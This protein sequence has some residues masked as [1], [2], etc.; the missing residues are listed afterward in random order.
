LPALPRRPVHRL[1]QTEVLM[2]QPLTLRKGK[3]SASILSSGIHI[4]LKCSTSTTTTISH[5]TYARTYVR[6][7]LRRCTHLHTYVP[8]YVVVRTYLHTYLPT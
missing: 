4:I 1:A 5:L 6:T 3:D 8:T 7:Y 2:L